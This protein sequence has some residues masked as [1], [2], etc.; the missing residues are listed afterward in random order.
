MNLFVPIVE[1][2]Y[3]YRPRGIANFEGIYA[4]ENNENAVVQE[5]HA[6]AGNTGKTKDHRSFQSFT[7]KW[8]LLELGLTPNGDIRIGS[9]YSMPS[10][11]ILFRVWNTARCLDDHCLHLLRDYL[12]SI[13]WSLFPIEKDAPN[14]DYHN[15]YQKCHQQPP[16]WSRRGWC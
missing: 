14:N 2:C 7:V 4:R 6:S 13:G 11:V 16:S 9:K 3:R 5:K 10:I 12:P 1:W 15:R 8:E